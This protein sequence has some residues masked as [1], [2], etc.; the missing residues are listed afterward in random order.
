MI[1]K[2]RITD[3]LREARRRTLRPPGDHCLD[4]SY[5][6]PNSTPRSSLQNLASPSEMWQKSWER[7]R[8]TW[9]TVR[10]SHTSTRQQ[11]WRSMRR[12]SQTVSLEGS[13]T[14]PRVPLKLPGKRW[15]RKMKRMRKKR[16]RRRNKTVDLSPSEY[17]KV[18]STVIDTPLTW[19]VSVALIRF[20]HP[21]GS[22]SYRSL[23][24]RSSNCQWF[25]GSGHG[26]LEHL[27][28][29]SKLYIFPNILKKKRVSCSP[30][31]VHFAVGMTRHLKM[32]LAFFIFLICKVVC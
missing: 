26:F 6:A 32:S 24:K 3:E 31:S 15:K 13:L 2:W 4:F 9:V 12:M 10:S 27:E 30:H 23:S 18:G 25:T 22:W 1:G 7:Y 8:I 16:R 11:S 29:V 21:V 14:V 5:S 28:T 17:L 20:N 19:D